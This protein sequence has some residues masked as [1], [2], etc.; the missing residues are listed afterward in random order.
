MFS[1]TVEY[2]LR[3][4]VHLASQGQAPQTTAQIAEATQVPSAYLSKVIQGLS[5]AGLLISQRGV[6]GGVRLAQTP[7]EL[8]ILDVVEAVDPVQRIRTC[9]LGLKAHGKKLCALHFRMDAALKQMEES[10]RATTLAEVIGDTEQSIP[11]VD[12]RRR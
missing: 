10:F 7:E 8:S 1:Q 9:P 3:A 4:M 2:A 11:L 5:R 12:R 6:G